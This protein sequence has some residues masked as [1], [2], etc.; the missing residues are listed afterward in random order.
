MS[1]PP[2]EPGRNYGFFLIGELRVIS[3][4]TPPSDFPDDQQW[5]HVSVSTQHHWQTPTWDQMCRIKRLFWR[6][7]ETVIQ[8]HPK[9]SR[10]INIH[11]GVLHLWKKVGVDHPL[12]DSK[13][14]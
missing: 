13:L 12:P 9:E 3:S 8:F 6:E 14:V 4:G 5:E 7:D 2:S 10:Y 1:D 11:P